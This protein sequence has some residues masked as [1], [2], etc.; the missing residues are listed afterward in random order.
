MQKPRKATTLVT[1][2]EK[3]EL[4]QMMLSLHQML[5]NAKLAELLILLQCLETG[6]VLQSN[7]CISFLTMSEQKTLQAGSVTKAACPKAV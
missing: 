3:K 6:L 5:T 4:Q 7:T 2:R 1:Q